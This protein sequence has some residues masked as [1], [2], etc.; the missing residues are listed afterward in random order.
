MRAL[1]RVFSSGDRKLFYFL[2]TNIK[3]S[4][5]DMVMLLVTNLGGVIFTIGFTLFLI[6]WGNGDTKLL[7]FKVL[8]ALFTTTFFVQILKKIV[9]RE[10][11]YN[12]LD[13]I[14]TFNIEMKDYS[15]P[16]GHTAASFSIATILYLNIPQLLIPVMLLALMVGISRIYLA[17]HY[18]SDVVVGMIVGCISSMIINSH[19]WKYIS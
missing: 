9:S 12:I 13:N 10:R 18:P 17:V 11:P 19:I 4:F 6:I 2:N 16:S 7:G 3:C 14:N 5:F 1:T 15:F 8:V